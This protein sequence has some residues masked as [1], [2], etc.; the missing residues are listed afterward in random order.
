MNN[1]HLCSALLF[2]LDGTL[3]D[4]LADIADAVNE[5]L[6]LFNLPL[7]PLDAYRRFVGDGVQMLLRRA[8]PQSLAERPPERFV[9]TFQELYRAHLNRKTRPYRGIA[10]ALQQL[11]QRMVPLAVLSNKPDE[12]AKLCVHRFFPSIA[13]SLVFGQRDGVPRKPDPA[14]ALSIAR[15]LQVPVEL[16]GFVGDSAVDMATG[17]AAGMTCIGVEWGF[18]ERAELEAAGADVI[19]DQPEALLHYAAFSR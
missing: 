12:L 18:R 6:G 3:I 2:D 19:I 17:K 7:H 9:E 10:D 8:L 14:A 16:C 13:F 5:T 15:A 1:S 11:Q 4:S